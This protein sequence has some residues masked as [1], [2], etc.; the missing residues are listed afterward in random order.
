MK[1]ILK[2]QKGQAILEFALVAIAFF[3]LLFGIVEV[4]LLV[5]NQQIV[6][7]AGREGARLGV[8]SRPTDHKVTKAMI[9]SNVKD[10]GERFVVSFTD[11]KFTVTPDFRS[12]V[13][14]APEDYCLEFQDMLTVDVSYDYSF[15]FLPF[16]KTLST[17]AVMLCE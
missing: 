5:Y 10:Y 12:K 7:N 9:I 2:D 11:K 4:G 6:T 3:T 14:N 8:V 13:D 1:D 17:R 15:L 16:K